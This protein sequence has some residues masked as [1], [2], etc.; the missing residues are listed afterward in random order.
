MLVSNSQ[1]IEATKGRWLGINVAQPQNEPRLAIAFAFACKQIQPI[2][3]EVT[4]YY[5]PVT[6]NRLFGSGKAAGPKP[7]LQGAIG[8]VRPL[9]LLPSPFG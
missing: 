6:M 5:S 7:T 2:P 9:P 3:S 8:N 4:L 1:A